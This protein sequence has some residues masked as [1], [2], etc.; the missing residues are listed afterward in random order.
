M[1]QLR[2]VLNIQ[3]AMRRT[4]CQTGLLLACWGNPAIRARVIL[5]LWLRE[6]FSLVPAPRLQ[7]AP[8]RQPS[9]Q[10]TAILCL[11]CLGGLNSWRASV[12]K[13]TARVSCRR[14]TRPG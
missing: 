13:Q 3:A 12:R 7:L 2:I 6:V 5:C 1:E 4:H 11:L 9:A 10:H 14:A 8:Q